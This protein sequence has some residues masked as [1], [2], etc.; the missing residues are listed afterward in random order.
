M[1]KIVCL[2]L[3]LTAFV[4]FAQNNKS[5]EF[6]KKLS[7]KIEMSEDSY[8]EFTEA[9]YS[10]INYDHYL[11]KNNKESL[12][13]FYYNDTAAASYGGSESNFFVSKN[14]MVP[15][16]VSGISKAVNYT[17]YGAFKILNEGQ[18]VTKLDRKG[19][20]GGTNCQYYAI[21]RDIDNKESYDYCFCIDESNKINNAESIF[22][23]S[24]LK[25]LI[26]SVEYNTESSYKLVYKSSQ[27][28]SL[29][30]DIDSDKIS[31]DIEEYQKSV[32][33][34][35][36][37]DAAAVAVDSVLAYGDYGSVYSDPLYTYNYDGSELQD[38]SL[39][40]YITPIYSVTTNALYNTKEYGGEGTLNRDQVASFYKKESKSLVKNLKSAKMITAD[41]KKELEK[42]FKTQNEKIKNYVPNQPIDYAATDVAEAYAVT[43]TA[44]YA[45]DYDYYTKYESSYKN[46]TID[47]IVLAYDLDVKDNEKIKE[48]APDYCDNLKSKIPN[49]QNKSLSTHVHNLTGQICDL[50]LY[51]NGGN[52]G[53]FETINSMRKS[54][55]EIEKLRSTL[56]QK[57]Q[58]LLLEFIKNLD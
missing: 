5:V 6:T 58:K 39:Y 56:S 24:K 52:V 40:S 16:S 17:P 21:L 23:D 27:N 25:G 42:F 46:E 30:L 12:L 13:S 41:Q 15:L 29:K 35:Y 8:N 44:A 34:E 45:E 22:P 54:Y 9:E 7:Y 19:T 37:V 31:A 1:K 36:P 51:N 50:Y 11:D 49:F 55:L 3:S 14:W 10:N 47:D 53:Y 43:D 4:G 38:Y 48:Y 28:V 57:D 26:L 33:E 32:V 18:T 20:I 2:A